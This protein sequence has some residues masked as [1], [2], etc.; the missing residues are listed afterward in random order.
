M[1]T[2][3]HEFGHLLLGATGI[4]NSG[5]TKSQSGKNKS[6]VWCNKFAAEFLVPLEE[7]KNKL[8]V[9]ETI[10]NSLNSLSKYYRVSKLVIL[11]R[12]FELQQITQSDYD[13]YRK[14]LSVEATNR[15]TV[16]GGGDFILT[17][18][19]RVGQKFAFAVIDSTLKGQTLY[20]DAFRMLGI[21]NI[22]TFNKLAESVGVNV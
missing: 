2:L 19:K 1:F 6:E 5:L 17:T 12:L 3:A 13:K 4:S 14:I 21:S 22:E 20:R 10:E 8:T 16:K 18:R 11:Y 9:K 7:L 15:K